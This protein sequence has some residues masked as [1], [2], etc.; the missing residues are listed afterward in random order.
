MSALTELSRRRTS[1]RRR[2]RR[3][4]RSCTTEHTLHRSGREG[5]REVGRWGM[6]TAQQRGSRTSPPIPLR[7][8]RQQQSDG[9]REE[10]VDKCDQLVLLLVLLLPPTTYH[11]AQFIRFPSRKYSYAGGKRPR[12]NDNGCI[13]LPRHDATRRCTTRRHVRRSERERKGTVLHVSMSQ[14]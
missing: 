14:I 10:L 12:A 4:R 1:R 9:R 13:K 6:A 8:Q 11:S 3:R 5:G 2:R 7:Q